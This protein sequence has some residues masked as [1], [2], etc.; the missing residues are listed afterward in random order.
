MVAALAWAAPVPAAAA[1][2]PCD[3]M[4]VDGAKVLG[5]ATEVARAAG[6]L[7]KHGAV[8][9]VR[10]YRNVP[11][12]NLDAAVRA[13]VRRCASWHDHGSARKP[14]LLV[15]AVDVANRK[16]AISYGSRWRAALD[17]EQQSVQTET[18]NPQL[19]RKAYAAGIAAGLRRIDELVTTEAAATTPADGGSGELLD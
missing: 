6:A 13:E 2:V 14:A 5:S 15:V 11:F 8:V 3:Q 7:R 9:R 17:D 16:T 10:T 12:G 18:I 4:I 1:A 19:K